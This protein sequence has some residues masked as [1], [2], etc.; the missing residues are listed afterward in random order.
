MVELVMKLLSFQGDSGAGV[1]V[2]D[3]TS[4][5]LTVL[6]VSGPRAAGMLD[7][8]AQGREAY[9]PG[10]LREASRRPL[11]E[12]RLLAPIPQPSRN[13]ICV[14][15][16]YRE[17]ARE[18]ASS[19]FDGSASETIP[20]VPVVFTKHAGSVIGPHDPIPASRDPDQSVDYEGELAVVIGQGGR[21]I[22]P[23]RAM[24]H[25]FG[26]TIINDVT[27]R[28]AQRRHK[29][30]FLGKSLDGFCPMGP[31]IVTRDELPD[32]AHAE[33]RTFVNGELR[34]RAR[35]ADLIF[36]IPALIATISRF[37]SLVPGD[38]IATGTPSGVGIGFDPPKFLRAGDE[39][40][41]QIDGVG[42]LRNPVV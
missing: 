7:V 39:V 16:N 26:Y 12:V 31:V 19:G 35:I 21:D 9:Q 11:S 2:L 22:A 1:G 29:Q 40:T 37:I 24:S 36:D 34:Q 33:L 8:I 25:V 23:E 27:A 14:G 13:I 28:H 15:K 6:P 4:T 41:I 38:I 5:M 42:E 17:H 30:W 20:E 18:F 10:A 3:E 32:I